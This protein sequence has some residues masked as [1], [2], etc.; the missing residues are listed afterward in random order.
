[1]AFDEKIEIVMDETVPYATAGWV[2][3]VNFPGLGMTEAL[4]LTSSLCN[5]L[6]L[7]EENEFHL[8]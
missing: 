2:E 4:D 7:N 3:I 8:G 1:M 5:Q 6:I